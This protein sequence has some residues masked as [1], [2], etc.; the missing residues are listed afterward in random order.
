MSNNENVNY[1]VSLDGISSDSFMK[2]V[3]EL[4]QLDGWQGLSN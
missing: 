2:L 1:P 4:Q 3:R